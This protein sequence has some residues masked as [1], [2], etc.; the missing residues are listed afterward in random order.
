MSQD[1]L[2]PLA[3]SGTGWTDFGDIRKRMRSAYPLHA[4]YFE[5]RNL[6]VLSA[7]EVAH[8]D[9]AP[10]KGPEYHISVAKQPVPNSVERCSAEEAKWVLEQFGLDGAEED[11]HVPNGKARNFWR[12]VADHL[13]GMECACKDVENV[14]V[15]GDY[16]TR[17][18]P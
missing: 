3:P 5:A 11:N 12:P 7:V 18:L 17:P 13:V 8:E 2:H 6:S 10:D 14:V 1:I 16:E 4:W 9:G 15:E